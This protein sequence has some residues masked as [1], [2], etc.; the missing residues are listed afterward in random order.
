[1]FSG[2]IGKLLVLIAVIAAVWY[3]WKYVTRLNQI[4]AEERRRAPRSDKRAVGV[5]EMRKCRTCGAY[6]AA[7]AGRCARAD[8]PL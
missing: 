5:E 3:G 8:C 4:R 1:M 7:D 2:P 6:V